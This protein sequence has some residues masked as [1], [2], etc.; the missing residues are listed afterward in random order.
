MMK[1][2]DRILVD[3]VG[4]IYRSYAKEVP[5]DIEVIKKNGEMAEVDWYKQGNMEW[6]GKYVIEVE[7]IDLPS[8]LKTKKK[9][10]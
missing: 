7:Y 1:V 2:I 4:Q 5:E 8:N 9:G 3:G 6:N 10:K